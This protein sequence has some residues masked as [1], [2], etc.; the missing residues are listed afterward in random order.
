MKV[1]DIYQS[2]MFD[3]IHEEIILMICKLKKFYPIE[4]LEINVRM[5][6]ELTTTVDIVYVYMCIH[7]NIIICK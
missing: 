3:L 2:L 5:Q 6:I 7:M 4:E 1:Y